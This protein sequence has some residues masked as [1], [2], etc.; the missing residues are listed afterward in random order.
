[1]EAYKFTEAV[2]KHYGHR[3]INSLYNK[4]MEILDTI[5]MGFK[6]RDFRDNIIEDFKLIGENLAQAL[7][8]SITKQVIKNFL[9]TKEV[10]QI[11]SIPVE[12]KSFNWM[13]LK[14]NVLNGRWIV[15]I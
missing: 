13:V 9:Q 1:M 12:R 11:T 15:Y 2:Y 10:Y 6:I 8:Q 3:A 4:C 5:E 7:R 14:I